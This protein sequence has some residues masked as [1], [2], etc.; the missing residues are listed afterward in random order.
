MRESFSCAFSRVAPSIQGRAW[1]FC[2]CAFCTSTTSLSAFSRA[3]PGKKR[4]TK[5]W[6]RAS[7]SAPSVML[8]QCLQ[9]GCSSLAPVKFFEVKAKFS[10]TK[11]RGRARARAMTRST[12]QRR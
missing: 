5:A 12:F 8:T 7:P 1:R 10:S 3:S 11:V 4:R 9:R 2:P 6:P